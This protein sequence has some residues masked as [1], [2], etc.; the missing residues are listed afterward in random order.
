MSDD[1]Q[2]PASFA[3]RQRA[4]AQG[5]FPVSRELGGTLALLAALA[6]VASCGPTLLDEL[7]TV[8]VQAWTNTTI[9]EVNTDGT[10]LGNGLDAAGNSTLWISAAGLLGLVWLL[11]VGGHWFQSGFRFQPARLRPSM[12]RLHPNSQRFGGGGRHRILATCVGTARWLVLLAIAG[13]GL[14]SCRNELAGLV[15]APREAWMAAA[16]ETV[17]RAV[18]GV[19]GGVALFSLIDWRLARWSFER[20]L[21]MSDEELRQDLRAEAVN[22]YL[23]ERQRPGRRP[24]A[25][26]ENPPA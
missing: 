9:R 21:R 11:T 25:P 12:A 2:H 1:R 23:A 10:Q 19:V 24:Q 17:F 18:L 7:K 4:R 8:A 5:D 13:G 22:P 6:I 3:Q 20:R 14:W 15:A 26:V 16:G